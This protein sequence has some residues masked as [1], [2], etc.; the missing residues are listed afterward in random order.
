MG[1]MRRTM[2][3]VLALALGGCVQ[4]LARQVPQ[5]DERIGQAP[6]DSVRTLS[7]RFNHRGLL[8]SGGELDGRPVAL[9]SAVRATEEGGKT[10]VCAALVVAGD[11]RVVEEVDRLVQAS[12]VRVFLGGAP[13]PY[14]PAEALP[15]QS[16]KMHVYRQNSGA[17][18]LNLKTLLPIDARC[19][20]TEL[21]WDPAYRGGHRLV[22]PQ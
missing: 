11:D 4:D 17:Q 2:A 14:R 10:R 12:R 20:R 6:G 15:P 18:P 22:V 19:A 8:F 3:L 9:F 21:E 13:R 7:G 5:A 16:L 1:A